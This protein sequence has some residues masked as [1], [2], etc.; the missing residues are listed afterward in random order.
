MA[1]KSTECIGQT[2]AQMEALII[3]LAR[4]R[5]GSDGVSVESMVEL[6]VIK[7]CSNHK[8]HFISTFRGHRKGS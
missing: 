2:Y 3:S 6:G 1:K 5:E 4:G 8:D 7:R